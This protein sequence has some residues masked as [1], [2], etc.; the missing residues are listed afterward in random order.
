MGQTIQQ[1]QQKIFAR[2]DELHREAA[3]RNPDELLTALENVY[4]FL[5]CWA[6]DFPH[7]KKNRLA[8]IAREAEYCRQILA[9]TFN[10]DGE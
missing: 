9:K 1:R 2:R 8:A 4:G 10:P 5:R 6:Q 7:S 3:R